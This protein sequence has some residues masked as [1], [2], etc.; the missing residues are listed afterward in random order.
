[1]TETGNEVVVF[2]S[3]VALLRTPMPHLATT[4]ASQQIP[5]APVTAQT[6]LL[7]TSTPKYDITATPAVSEHQLSSASHSH[8]MVKLPSR[9]PSSVEVSLNAIEVQINLLL[10]NQHTIMAN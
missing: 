10:A 5:A 2:E 3:K 7:L 6:L 1:M 8:H 4:T 9:A